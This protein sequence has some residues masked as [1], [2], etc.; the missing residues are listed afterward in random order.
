MATA[1]AKAKKSSKPAKN[2]DLSSFIEDKTISDN[3]V[4]YQPIEMTIRNQTVGKMVYSRKLDEEV[5]KNTLDDDENI[6]YTNVIW[7]TIPD[8]ELLPVSLSADRLQKHR[9]A[10]VEIDAT[11]Y[12]VAGGSNYMLVKDKISHF[13][14][15]GTLKAKYRPLTPSAIG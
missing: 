6:Q 15:T 7:V 1:N 12:Q 4:N 2:N 13:A 5:W 8:T 3:L 10:L 11:P 9:D 14:D